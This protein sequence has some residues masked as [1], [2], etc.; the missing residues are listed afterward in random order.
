MN[1][2]LERLH[3]LAMY[4]T[5]FVF[6]CARH[7]G[8]CRG[9]TQ[10]ID[11][12]ISKLT[13]SEQAELRGKTVIFRNAECRTSDPLIAFALMHANK[14]IGIATVQQWPKRHQ[15]GK[16]GFVSPPSDSDEDVDPAAETADEGPIAQPV[17]EPEPTD[18][19]EP[20]QVVVQFKQR[21]KYAPRRRKAS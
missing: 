1:K 8:L 12:A 6:I 5:T 13:P 14:D 17:V 16:V 19:P 18:L 21:R 15:N 20:Q 9:A 11:T 10:V 4:G 3:H 7:P 2:Q